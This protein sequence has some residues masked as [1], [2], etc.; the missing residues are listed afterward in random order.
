MRPLKNVQFSPIF[1]P[2]VP[3]YPTV[4]PIDLAVAPF[5][6][7]EFAGNYAKADD[8]FNRRNIRSFRPVIYEIY[9]G[10]PYVMG[11]P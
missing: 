1:K 11:N 3:R 6:V 9:N 4:V 7:V 8:E 5:P 2:A 10:I